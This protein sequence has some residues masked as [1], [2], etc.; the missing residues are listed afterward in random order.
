MITLEIVNNF[1]NLVKE[2]WEKCNSEDDYIVLKLLYN[3]SRNAVIE[4]K[5]KKLLNLFQ[6]ALNNFRNSS[7]GAIYERDGWLDDHTLKDGLKNIILN[8]STYKKVDE[9][10]DDYTLDYVAFFSECC[11]DFSSPMYSVIS[12]YKYLCQ[13]EEEEKKQ[14]DND[15]SILEDILGPYITDQTKEFHSTSESYIYDNTR[16]RTYKTLWYEA[17][18]NAIKFYE[19]KCNIGMRGYKNIRV[20]LDVVDEVFIYYI[21]G[22]KNINIKEKN[23]I[24][25]LQKRVSNRVSW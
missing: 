12:A 7:V 19:E 17:R 16:A 21:K 9:I 22:P 6:L 13:I 20:I 1:R 23:K 15:V 18:N 24:K 5:K 11:D 3:M 14:I 2:R 10:F 25:S 4:E 8:S